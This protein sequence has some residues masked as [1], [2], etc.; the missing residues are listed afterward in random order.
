MDILHDPC[1]KLFL[2]PIP[3]VYMFNLQYT[4]LF[5][6]FYEVLSKHKFHCRGKVVAVL[7]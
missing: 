6:T 5:V 3:A 4:E 2:L 1:F 7:N